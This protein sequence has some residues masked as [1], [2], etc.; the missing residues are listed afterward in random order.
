[1]NRTQKWKDNIEDLDPNRVRKKKQQ[2]LK[3]VGVM[4]Q[5]KEILYCLAADHKRTK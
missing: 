3:S 1:M 5:K 2:R 4:R